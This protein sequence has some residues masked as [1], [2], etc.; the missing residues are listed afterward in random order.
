MENPGVTFNP[1]VR[2]FMQINSDPMRSAE[3]LF[4]LKDCVGD[5]PAESTRVSASTC[6]T[7]YHYQDMGNFM[8]SLSS[9]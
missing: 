7:P 2:I 5:F 1:F 9:K 8:F 3:L 4:N 6:N